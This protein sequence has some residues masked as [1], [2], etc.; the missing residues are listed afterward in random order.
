M[1]NEE[2]QVFYERLGTI[3][4]TGTP[5]YH[6]TI[7]YTNNIGQSFIASCY[8]VAAPGVD[9]PTTLSDQLQVMARAAYVRI[10][11]HA[12][13]TTGST[14]LKTLHFSQ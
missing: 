6:E 1:Q 13:T 7:L 12:E 11:S 8:A 14:P 4:L 5:Y 2:I 10:S 3:P 9:A